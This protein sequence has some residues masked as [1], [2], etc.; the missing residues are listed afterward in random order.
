LSLFIFSGGK[1]F[2][3]SD[4]EYQIARRHKLSC[5]AV[6]NTVARN[7]LKRNEFMFSH[8][9]RLQSIIEGSQGRAGLKQGRNLEAGTEE[10]WKG[11][12]L[13]DLLSVACS[14]CFHRQPK[15]TCPGIMSPTG[16]MSHTNP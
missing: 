10:E 5:F 8:T 9:S 2:A 4:S 6:I 16:G 7:N 11:A 1:A 12:L 13:T 14:T 3:D 15:T